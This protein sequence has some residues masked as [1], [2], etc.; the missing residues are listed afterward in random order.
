VAWTPERVETLKNMWSEGQ[1]ASQIAGELGGVTRNA[2]I[3]KVHRLGLSNRGSTTAKEK[4]S[5]Q[6]KEKRKHQKVDTELFKDSV[7]ST[8][9]KNAKNSTEKEKT[10]LEPTKK[11]PGKQSFQSVNKSII[12]TANQPLPPQPSTSEI[13]EETLKNVKSLE[14]KSKKT[15]PNGTYGTNM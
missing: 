13:S 11:D 1:S 7:T 5:T 9:L 12:F 15:V 6:L 3:G 2:V 4:K 8:H 14:K 10:S